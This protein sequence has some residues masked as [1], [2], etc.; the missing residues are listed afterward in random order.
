LG[1]YGTE[2]MPIAA[3]APSER[4]FRPVG[5]R[6][7]GPK[8]R[9]LIGT[10]ERISEALLGVAIAKVIDT[11]ANVIPGFRD[12]YDRQAYRTPSYTRPVATGEGSRVQR[13]DWERDER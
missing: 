10:W 12:Q 2:P 1:T 6:G 7:R 8:T 4:R 9:E 11:V 13:D 3:E 5:E